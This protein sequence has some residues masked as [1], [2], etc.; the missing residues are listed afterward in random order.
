MAVE[1]EGHCNPTNG[2]NN[3]L[4]EKRLGGRHAACA[5]T[6][7]RG[8]KR[9]LSDPTSCSSLRVRAPVALRACMAW[10]GTNQNEGRQGGVA[11]CLIET[12]LRAFSAMRTGPRRLSVLC[13]RAGSLSFLVAGHWSAR[14]HVAGPAS[15]ELPLV[16]GVH[17]PWR[18][19]WTGRI[20]KTVQRLVCQKVAKLNQAVSRWAKASMA[21]SRELLRGHPRA[22]ITNDRGG[23]QTACT[24]NVWMDAHTGWNIQVYTVYIADTHGW[25]QEAAPACCLLVWP[26]PSRTTLRDNKGAPG[27][28][29]GHRGHWA[30]ER[31][32]TVGPA[33]D[34]CATTSLHTNQP[35]LRPAAPLG[36]GSVPRVAASRDHSRLPTVRQVLVAASI[37][38]W[39]VSRRL[40]A[41]PAAISLTLSLST[42]SWGPAETVG[43]PR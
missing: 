14:L 9:G 31:Q 43:A 19:V 5:A 11:L 29:R 8:G 28:H 35:V 33:D 26:K 27:G 37:C 41:Q 38:F 2:S 13:F 40:H 6:I 21:V 34:A 25:L 12:A 7:R 24:T 22:W 18:L 20:C 15:R 1:R 42:P 23:V 39:H 10:A 32:G 3:R 16:R 30:R 17:S 36:A 4:C